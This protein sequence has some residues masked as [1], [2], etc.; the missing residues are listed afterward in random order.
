MFHTC[1][2]HDVMVWEGCDRLTH[3]IVSHP[4]QFTSWLEPII[5]FAA[6][7]PSETWSS[8]HKR[9]NSC[10]LG[11]L[12]LSKQWP[13]RFALGDLVFSPQGPQQLCP[14]W[15]G[16][17]TTRASAVVPSATWSSHNKGCSSR[18]LG[19]LILSP[20]GQQG[21]RLARTKQTFFAIVNILSTLYLLFS[22][23]CFTQLLQ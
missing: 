17:L 8:H 1:I 21:G 9:L 20:Q 4:K 12:V 23:K 14:R 11:D 13:Q 18:A 5:F 7:V 3:F 22:V 10:A 6:V 2:I 16:P 15:P 19:D